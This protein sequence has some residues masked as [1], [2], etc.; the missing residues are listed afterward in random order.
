MENKCY[1]ANINTLKIET[2]VLKCI[3]NNNAYMKK[4][5]RLP[6]AINGEYEIKTED[7]CISKN[8]VFKDKMQAEKTLFYFIRNLKR[9]YKREIKDLKSAILF[10]LKYDINENMININ[11]IA[12]AALKER[13][14]ELKIKMKLAFEL[15]N[16]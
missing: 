14:K 4:T 5:Y 10:I 1:Y 13:C 12:E 3:K 15:S 16:K 9:T 8:Y 7:I 11:K 2:G 6:F